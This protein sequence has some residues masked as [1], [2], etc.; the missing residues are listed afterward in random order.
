MLLEKYSARVDVS[1]LHASF[2][3]S[4]SKGQRFSV[5]TL[6]GDRP[7][8]SDERE[9]QFFSHNMLEAFKRIFPDTRGVIEIKPK[10]KKPAPE[11]A[12]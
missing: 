4:K 5:R 10:K 1:S 3:N 12:N 7:I 8:L 9:S 2:V 11:V 6:I